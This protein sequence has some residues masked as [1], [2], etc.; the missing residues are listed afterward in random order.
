MDAAKRNK[1]I[2][3]AYALMERTEE[4]LNEPRPEPRRGWTPR[5]APAPEPEPEPVARRSTDAML[6]REVA[7]LRADYARDRAAIRE[8]LGVLA[9]EA[10]AECGRLQKQVN[11][12]TAQIDALKAANAEQKAT[13]DELRGEINLLRALQP[14]RLLSRK[15]VPPQIEGAL[16]GRACVN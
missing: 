5:Q 14:K 13:N 9:D 8:C 10:G 3:R 16:S 7:Q 6:A 1:I 11:E 15:S 12:L 2:E 4:M